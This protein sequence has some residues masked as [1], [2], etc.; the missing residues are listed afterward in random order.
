MLILQLNPK[1]IEKY[2][3]YKYIVIVISSLIPAKLGPLLTPSLLFGQAQLP[4]VVYVF[5]DIS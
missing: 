2:I 1:N 4:G 5:L 3:L